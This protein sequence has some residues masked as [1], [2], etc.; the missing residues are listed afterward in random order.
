M[1]GADQ[2]PRVSYL[3][4]GTPRTGSTL[5]CDLLTD[6]G[7]A[8][9]PE[10]YFRRP[11]LDAWADRWQLPR[12]D[13]RRYARRDYAAAVL[14][15]GSTANGVFGCRVMWGSV[16]ELIEHFGGGEDQH[17]VLTRALGPVRIIHIAR[18]DTVAQAVSWARA[19]Q[20]H[21]WQ[22]GDLART[23]PTYDADQIATLAST[24]SE[25]NAAWEAWFTDIGISPHRVGYEELAADPRATLTAILTHLGLELAEDDLPQPRRHRQGDQVN[26]EW[27]ARFRSSA[28]E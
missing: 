24:I 18:D 9:R 5:L 17:R 23:E 2:Q 16:P 1:S 8:G 13:H 12:D 19:E 7:I 25:H 14:R 20:T 21:Y 10:S 28:Y 11:D 27:A 6:T 4:C 3:L 15:A 26:R 22:H